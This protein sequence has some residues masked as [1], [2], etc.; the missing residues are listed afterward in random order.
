MPQSSCTGTTSTVNIS[1]IHSLLLLLCLKYHAQRKTHL[2]TCYASTHSLYALKQKSQWL[3]TRDQPSPRSSTA[4]MPKKDLVLRRV[5]LKDY[6]SNH[7]AASS[8]AASS[9]HPERSAWGATPRTQVKLI[10]NTVSTLA[11]QAMIHD[12]T[13]RKLNT[14]THISQ[15]ENPLRLDQEK[16]K[17]H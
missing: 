6:H 12:Q 10:S 16:P 8:G 17:I 1:C 2:R 7:I 11:Q 4:T 5:S 9:S 14:Q 3:S 13:D 15:S